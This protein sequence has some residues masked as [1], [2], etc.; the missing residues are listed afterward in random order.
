M[1]E[2]QD[3]AIMEDTKLAD[4][5][6]Q[7]IDMFGYLGESLD[8]LAEETAVKEPLDDVI[9]IFGQLGD[10]LD[11]FNK[12]V[13]EKLDAQ[14]ID[15]IIDTFGQLGEHL[16]AFS[17]SMTEKAELLIIEPIEEFVGTFD[18]VEEE[19]IHTFDPVDALHSL[20]EVATEEN[21]IFATEEDE[22]EQRSSSPLVQVMN[23]FGNLW[24]SLAGLSEDV[25]ESSEQ[26]SQKSPH[27]I[28]DSDVHMLL[29]LVAAIIFLLVLSVLICSYCKRMMFERE[30]WREVEQ[31]D[32]DSDCSGSWISIDDSS[33]QITRH[34]LTPTKDKDQLVSQYWLWPEHQISPSIIV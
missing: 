25:E 17:E 4:P 15:E 19:F 29:F 20:A 7:V 21:V 9:D 23:M 16:N 27:H 30:Q 32:T 12:D 34:L 11:V 26:L 1:P 33:T 5:L 14:P 6:G 24:E 2:S 31:Q 28:S 22:A 8:I 13:A 18:P 3:I 10:S